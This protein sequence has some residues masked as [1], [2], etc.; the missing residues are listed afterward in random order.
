[1][2]I[3]NDISESLVSLRASSPL[4]HHITN[5]VTINEC[6]NITLAIGASPVMAPS[7]DESAHMAAIAS[8]LVLNI[9]TLCVESVDS[10]ISAGKSAN[11][12]GTPVVFDPVGVGVTDLR[13]ESSKRII[14]EVGLSVIRGNASE[15]MLL[16]G[17][18]ASIKGVDSSCES[19]CAFEC[20]KALASRL[21]C[22]VAVTGA[23]DIITDGKETVKI[24][25]G[26]QMLSRV[27]GTGCMCTSL[28]ASFCAA[29]AS[30]L[31]AAAAGIMVMGIAGQLAEATL[32]GLEG[33]GTFRT[34]LF[35][36][37]Y[38]LSPDHIERYG[39]VLYE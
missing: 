17:E 6:A 24:K 11:S 35:D 23:I 21:S 28:I 33:I 30:P 10:M 36:A 38:A 32:S 18:S 34:R 31:T 37:V 20:A 9:G 7:I 15:I 1:M 2:D 14:D 12:N 5:S 29:G 27:T 13:S 39:D 26:T 8:S 4:V 19:L 3:I 25:N 22:T 16:C